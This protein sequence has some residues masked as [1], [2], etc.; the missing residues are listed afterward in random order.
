LFVY[1]RHYLE[2][3]LPSITSSWGKLGIQKSDGILI[4]NDLRTQDE[5]SFYMDRKYW[6][7]D[8][9]EDFLKSV[10]TYWRGLKHKDV[11]KGLWFDNSSALEPEQVQLVK[12]TNEELKAAIAKHG[13]LNLTDYDLNYRYQLEKRVQDL[14]KDIITKKVAYS[15]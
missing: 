13:P 10:T 14:K 5:N 7:P 8:E 11:N 3:T 12:K 15:H 1:E 6:N 2:H 9:R 4:L